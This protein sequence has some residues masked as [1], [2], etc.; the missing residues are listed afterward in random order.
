MVHDGGVVLPVKAQPGAR[1]N[2]IIGPHA[3]RLKVSVTAA[4]EAGKANDAIA[5]LLANS[6][7]IPRSQIQLVAGQTSRQKKFLIV[8]TTLDELTETIGLLLGS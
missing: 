6:L 8:D 2:T 3:G 1:R 5:E 4:P 7:H